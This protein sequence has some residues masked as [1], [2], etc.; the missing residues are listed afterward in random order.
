M[1]SKLEVLD[2]VNSLFRNTLKINAVNRHIVKIIN[3]YLTN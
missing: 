2:L 1:I 3:I